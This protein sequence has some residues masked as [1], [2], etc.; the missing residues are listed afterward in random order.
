MHPAC[1]GGVFPAIPEVTTVTAT[2][3]RALILLAAALALP[4]AA[5]PPKNEPPPLT[6]QIVSVR[7]IGGGSDET[8]SVM[9]EI[10]TGRSWVLVQ[11]GSAPPSWQALAF[12]SGFTL[13]QQLMPPELGTS[14]PGSQK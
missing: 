10:Q 3:S 5:A 2:F 8:G 9:L 7:M 4:A 14:R 13:N 11:R 1:I 6:Y 12:E